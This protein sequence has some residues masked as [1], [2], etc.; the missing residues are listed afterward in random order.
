MG[1]SWNKSKEFSI[2]KTVINFFIV[3]RLVVRSRDFN[4]KFKLGNCLFQWIKL[5]KNVD[6]DKYGY[7]NRFDASQESK[8]ESKGTLKQ[9][10]E[11]LKRIKDLIKSIKN[12]A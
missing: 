4:T 10:E 3:Y 5:T 2:L 8:D 11:L 6:P 12:I 1:A 7:G 9:Y